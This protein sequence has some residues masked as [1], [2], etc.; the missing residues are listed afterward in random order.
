MM[1]TSRG[2]RGSAVLQDPPT[3]PTIASLRGECEG[4][5]MELVTIATC[6]AKTVRFRGPLHQE[7]YCTQAAWLL[8]DLIRFMG[9]RY[10]WCRVATSQRAVRV[11]KGSHWADG[12]CSTPCMLHCHGLQVQR[13]TLLSRDLG[14]HLGH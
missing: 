6:T 11:C 9:I 7:L 2:S 5:G 8:W 13:A 10:S 12:L 3:P 4:A 14:W 1:A